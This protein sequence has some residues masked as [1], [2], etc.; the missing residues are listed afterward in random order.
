MEATTVEGGWVDDVMTEAMAAPADRPLTPEARRRPDAAE[1]WPAVLA[2]SREWH[3]L[4]Y[5]PKL[6]GV[7]DK[8]YNDNRLSGEYELPDLQLAASELLRPQYDVSRLEAAWL[9][10]HAEP[11]AICTAVETAMFD[12]APKP[13]NLSHW[14]VANLLIN[15]IDPATLP[16]AELPN[17][18]H[19]LEKGRR[20][21]PRHLLIAADAYRANRSGLLEFAR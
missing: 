15:G 4:D 2:D 6:G 17:V 1:G 11:Q 9:I 18:M 8:L 13:F 21:I 7:W 12:L 19:A 14:I 10:G 5:M 16:P 3:L 20:V